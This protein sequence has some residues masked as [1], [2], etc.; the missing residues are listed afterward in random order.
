MPTVYG[1]HLL[2]AMQGVMTDRSSADGGEQFIPSH[3]GKPQRSAPEQVGPSHCTQ[4]IV[5]ASLSK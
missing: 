4:V 5:Y 2:R 1:P 3:G